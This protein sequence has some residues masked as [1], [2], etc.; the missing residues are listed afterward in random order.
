[1]GCITDDWRQRE[2]SC[3]LLVFLKSHHHCWLNIAAITWASDGRKV[4]DRNRICIKYNMILLK[5]DNKA[6]QMASIDNPSLC[7]IMMGSLPVP[8]FNCVIVDYHCCHRSHRYNCRCDHHCHIRL[9]RQISE[10]SKG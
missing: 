5:N 10:S 7:Y 6:I 8:F 3:Q 1:M 4:N 9:E 2:R